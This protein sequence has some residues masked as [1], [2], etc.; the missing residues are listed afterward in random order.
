VREREWN[1]EKND[2]KFCEIRDSD[3]D[4]FNN[5]YKHIHICKYIQT[6][7]SIHT[8]TNTTREFSF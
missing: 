1:K 4:L 2:V 7:T 5:E 8:C 3:I 6:N